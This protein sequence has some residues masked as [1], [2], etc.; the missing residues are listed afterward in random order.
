MS[1]VE[2]KSVEEF[3]SQIY[4]HQFVL[5]DF[6][7]E[8]CG[9]CKAIKPFIKKLPS[10]HPGLVVL[11]VDVDVNE[12]LSKNFRIKS[13]PTFMMFVDGKRTKTIVGASEDSI[14]N[15][16]SHYMSQ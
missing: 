5:V 13:V 3:E 7:A 10:S 6:N 8:W 11:D 2:I 12:E 9:P 1:L 4:K 14:K 16:V 15:C